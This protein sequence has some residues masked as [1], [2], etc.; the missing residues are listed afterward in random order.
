VR[1]V[2]GNMPWD[3]D[4]E[5]GPAHWMAWHRLRNNPR[6]ADGSLDPLAYVPAADLIG[7]AV[8]QAMGPRVKFSMVISLEICLHIFARTDSEWLL[9]DSHASQAR[10]GYVSGRVDLWDERGQLVAQAT[11]LATIKPMVA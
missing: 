10:D 5:A 2:L 4:W 7:P 1:P 3:K 9:Q 6:L 8:R 11:Q